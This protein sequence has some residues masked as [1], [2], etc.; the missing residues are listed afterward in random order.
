MSSSPGKNISSTCLTAKRVG[1]VSKP[2]GGSRTEQ[3]APRDCPDL[4][5]ESPRSVSGAYTW[6]QALQT[7]A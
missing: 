1:L 2:V 6:P 5:R 7:R 3:G 4:Q